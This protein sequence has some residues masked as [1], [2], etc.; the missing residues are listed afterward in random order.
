MSIDDYQREFGTTTICKV[1]DDYDLEWIN[2]S[3]RDDGNLTKFT[4]AQGGQMFVIVSQVNPRISNKSDRYSVGKT[5]IVL[6]RINE[7]D[8]LEYLSHK[9]DQGNC[10][11]DLE[12]DLA[13]G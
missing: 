1:H 8:S 11:T 5:R 10:D 13:P 2:Q 6:A 12:L 9:Y 4:M 3:K 7:H